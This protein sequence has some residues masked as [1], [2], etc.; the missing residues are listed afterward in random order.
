MHR[1]ASSRAFSPIDVGSFSLAELFHD[2]GSQADNGEANQPDKQD[3][4]PGR[5][6]LDRHL[7][8]CFRQRPHVPLPR[9]TGKF[10]RE[11][12]VLSRDGILPLFHFS[13]TFYGFSG[14]FHCKPT[15]NGSAIFLHFPRSFAGRT[16]EGR[17][18]LVAVTLGTPMIGPKPTK[19][20]VTRG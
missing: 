19:Y 13:P 16:R 9:P 5:I 2:Q 15:V 11:M 7:A 3:R 6:Q 17:M 8:Q 4:E 14:Q 18:K 1:S 10:S 12:R 20:H